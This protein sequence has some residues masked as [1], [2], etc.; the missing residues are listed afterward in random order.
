MARAAG[1]ANGK[2][3]PPKNPGI[4]LDDEVELFSARLK[5]TTEGKLAGPEARRNLDLRCEFGPPPLTLGV[6]AQQHHTA[7]WSSLRGHRGH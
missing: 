4:T 5:W 7:Y 3:R 1:S 6:Y 2:R